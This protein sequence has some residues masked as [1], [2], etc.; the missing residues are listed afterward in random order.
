M[1]VSVASKSEEEILKTHPIVSNLEGW[2]FKFDET[3]N[4]VFVVEATD[5]FGRIFSK[6]GVAP[7]NLQK[8]IEEEIMLA[9]KA[10]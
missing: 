3:S 8:E 6:H 7:I 1:K 9:F 4:N 5:R 10:N 2:F